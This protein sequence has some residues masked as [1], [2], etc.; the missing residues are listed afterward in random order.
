[1][2]APA[3]SSLPSIGHYHQRPQ[4]APAAIWFHLPDAD[5]PLAFGCDQKILPVHVKRIQLLVA[6]HRF[7]DRFFVGLRRSDDEGFSHGM[8]L[9]ADSRNVNLTR[10]VSQSGIQSGTQ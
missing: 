7:D 3:D 5:D 9:P 6:N 1:M 8:T 4:L 10:S 2:I